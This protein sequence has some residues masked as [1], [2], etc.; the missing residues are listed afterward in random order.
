MARSVWPSRHG[1]P[2]VS[3]RITPT[4]APVSARMPVASAR[5]GGIGIDR[6]QQHRAVRRVR[7]VDAGGRADDALAVLD[8]A[9]DAAL[10][11]AGRDD[12]HRLG[13]DRGLAVVGLHDA[14]LRLRDDLRGDDE[15]VAVVELGRAC[16]E[17]GE[18][19]ALRD[20]GQALDAFDAELHGH[21]A[22]PR[23]CLDPCRTGGVAARIRPWRALRA[24]DRGIRCPRHPARP[25]R[26]NHPRP[27]AAPTGRG[28]SAD[29]RT[30]GAGGGSRLPRRTSY[31]PVEPA[32]AAADAAPTKRPV[33]MW[34][35]ILT[36]VLLVVMIG[37]TLLA[38]FLSFFL[39]FAGDSCGSRHHV[40]LRPHWPPACSSP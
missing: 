38:S 9:G 26:R 25:S 1:R 5:G 12:A 14:P 8:D 19:V 33:I 28:R 17:R 29:L 20:L 6:Q 24:A 4:R 2:S 11:L 10:V 3:E 35:L 37:V 40:R 39:A 27:I 30:P 34:D 36:I 22:S 18:V 13:G 21:P 15:D 32:Y 16:D 7:R 31:G 23:S